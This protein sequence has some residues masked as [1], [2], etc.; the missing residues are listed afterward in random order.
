MSAVS[1]R[2]QSN[3]KEHI[4]QWLSDSSFLTPAPITL[5]PSVDGS[6]TFPTTMNMVNWKN[7]IMLGDFAGECVS[8][9]GAI[10][11]FMTNSTFTN[12]VFLKGTSGGYGSP[13][14]GNIFDVAHT[15]FP[16]LNSTIHYVNGTGGYGGAADYHLDPT[17]PYSAANSSA[18]LLSTDGTDLGADIDLVNMASSGAAAGTPPWDQM[19]GLRVNPGSSQLVFRYTAPT[20]DACT[21]TI[22]RA[23]ARIPANQVAS[24]ADNSANSISDA[25]T[26]ELYVSGLQPSTPYWYKLACGGGVLLVGD[27]LTRKT[28]TVPVQFGFDWNSPTPMQYSSSP[29]MSNPVSLPAATRQFVPV[30]ANSVVYVQAGTAGPITMLIAP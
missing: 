12:N 8:Q 1:G 10:A 15:A 17:S 30:A 21:A 20:S 18:T 7:S 2:H 19:A 14:A 22:Y 23:P 24:I 16:T 28:G 3:T 5:S 13:G 25:L 26:R 4:T 11:A 29:T 9:G 27:L 6:C